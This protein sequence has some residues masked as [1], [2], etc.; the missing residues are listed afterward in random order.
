MSKCYDNDILFRPSEKWEPQWD[1]EVLTIDNFY[2]NADMIYQWLTNQDYPLWKY[3]PE[4]STRNNVDYRDARLI[5]KIGHPSRQY[6]GNME[7]LLDICRKYWHKG[8]YNWDMVYE[9]NCFQTITIDDPKVQHYPHIDSNLESMDSE[10][11]LNMLVYLDI[12]DSGGTAIYH[13][14]WI[15]NDENMNLMYPVEE[16]FKLDRVIEHKFNRCVIFAGNRMH[17]AYINDYDKYKDNWRFTQVNF[18]HP[19]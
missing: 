3:N 17:G 12:E 19:C 6:H 11:V 4:S 13:G 14:E 1:G 16:R 7:R 18:F 5:H 2:E 15:T 9:F 8:N 10:S